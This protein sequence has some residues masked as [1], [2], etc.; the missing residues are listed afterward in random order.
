M[1]GRLTGA[2][3]RAQRSVVVAVTP[4]L[5]G[6]S[7]VSALADQGVAATSASDGVAAE[8][9]DVAVVSA[10]RQDDVDADVVIRLPDVPDGSAALRSAGRDVVISLVGLDDLRLVLQ[11]LGD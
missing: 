10:D 8:H 1:S 6:D 11:R 2:M 4:R 5:L 7:L 9:F 3:D